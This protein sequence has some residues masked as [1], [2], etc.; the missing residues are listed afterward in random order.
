MINNQLKVNLIHF[1]TVG[2]DSKLRREFVDYLV[3]IQF[4]RL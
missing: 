4:F 3:V 2:G 1:L